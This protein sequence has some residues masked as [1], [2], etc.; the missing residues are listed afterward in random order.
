MNIFKKIISF[1]IIFFISQG[2]PVLSRAISTNL[3]KIQIEPLQRFVFYFVQILIP[4]LI[5]KLYTR[6]SI[7]QMGFNTHNRNLSFKTLKSFIK[8]WTVVVISF[9]VLA[10]LFYKGFGTYIQSK[11]PLDYYNI[12]KNFIDAVLLAGIGEEPLFR[13][14]VVLILFKYWNESFKIG[15]FVVPYVS[16]LSGF[17]F[18]I[19]HVGFSVY[20]Y[21]TI[22]YYD[23]LQLAFTFVLG[24]F[25][26]TVFVKTKSLLCPILAHSSANAIQFT[27]GYITSF[28]IE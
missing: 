1:S 18:M 9:F 8:V 15:K 13:G 7:S 12:V 10:L 5:L 6:K 3:L 11:C 23:P 22:T 21:F 20:P 28:L 24:T 16:I 4:I 27:I 19:A 26:A 25:W 17:I 2:I 14:L